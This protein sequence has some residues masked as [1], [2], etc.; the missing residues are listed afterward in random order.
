MAPGDGGVLRAVKTAVVDQLADR[1][2]DIGNQAIA[3]RQAGAQREVAFGH[4]EGHV[5][6]VDIAPLGGDTAAMQNQAGR[7]AARGH[8]ADNLV[9]RWRLGE[10]PGGQGHADISVHR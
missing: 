4:A 2:V 6:A 3:N 8:R 5:D 7:P 9:E 1:R 10:M